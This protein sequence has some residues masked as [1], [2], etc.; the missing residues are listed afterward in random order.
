MYELFALSYV[1]QKEINA[2]DFFFKK[3]KIK[4]HK[5]EYDWKKSGE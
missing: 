1:G 2:F 3:M 4:K 5:T